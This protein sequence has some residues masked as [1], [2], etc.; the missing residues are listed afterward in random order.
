MVVSISGKKEWRI[1]NML[2]NPNPR[3]MIII[4]LDQMGYFMKN[5]INFLMINL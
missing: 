4:A 3:I 5:E 1:V 2:N